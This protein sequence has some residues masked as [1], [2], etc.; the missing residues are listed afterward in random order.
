LAVLIHA[1]C[2]N[3]SDRLKAILPVK[4]ILEKSA[5]AELKKL[6]DQ[7]HRCDF[8]L[9]KIDKEL[10]D[11]A[12]MLIHQGGII[13]EG[14]NAGLDELRS[15]AFSGKDYLVQIQKR[16]IERTGINSL[17]I[18]FNKVFGYYLEVSNANKDK[19]PTDWIRKQTLVNAERYITEE[20]KVYEEKILHAEEK[21]LVI[22]Q[23]L[24]LE[25]VHH[26]SDYV[27]QIQQNARVVGCWIACFLLR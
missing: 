17:K 20:L 25:L 16:E 14:V 26:A 9:E 11:D 21:L 13:K 3:L 1:N 10:M 18:S 23:R 4:E 27:A 7:L 5:S 6:G 12:P 19:V 8:L 15:L 22:E 2:F 24:F